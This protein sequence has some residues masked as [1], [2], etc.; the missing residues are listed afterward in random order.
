[1]A[2]RPAQAEAQCPTRPPAFWPV[3]CSAVLVGMMIASEVRRAYHTPGTTAD[4]PATGAFGIGPSADEPVAA[5]RKRTQEPGRG[6]H[7]QTPWQ[8]PWRGWKDIL[9]RMTPLVGAGYVLGILR[10][11]G[12]VGVVDGVRSIG[13]ASPAGAAEKRCG[14]RWS[15]ATARPIA[16]GVLVGA[17]LPPLLELVA[18]DRRLRELRG[19]PRKISQLCAVTTRIRLHPRFV[20]AAC[21]IAKNDP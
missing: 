11:N 14:E 6:R 3:L 7:A 8:I 4:R 16:C 21:Q 2:A 5:Q 12:A 17:G 10:L 15:P 19:P 18:K 13:E 9:W 1:M 20:S